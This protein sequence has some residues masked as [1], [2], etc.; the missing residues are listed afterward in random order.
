MHNIKIKGNKNMYNVAIIGAGVIGSSIFAKLTRKGI[1]AVLL[2]KG[3]DVSLGCS[4]ANSGI[5]HAGF[6]AKPNTLKARFNVEGNKM[7]EKVCEELSIPFKKTG[8]FVVGDSEEQI[9]ELIKKGKLNG[10]SNLEKMDRTQMLKYIPNLAEGITFGL[11]AKDSGIVSPYLLTIAMAEEGVINGGEV[12]FNFEVVECTKD[13]EKMVLKSS[14]G[15]TIECQKVINCAGEGYNAVAKILGTEEFSITF[16]RGEYFLL[17]STTY[18]L[19]DYTIF[20]L[21][22]KAGKGILIS[23][24]I[25]GNIIVGPT[26]YESGPSTETTMDGLNMIRNN[27]SKVISNVPLNK[28]IREFSGVRVISGD[29]FVVQKSQKDERVIMLAGICSPGLTSAPSI[30]KYVVEELLGYTNED[31]VKVKR[32][33][34]TVTRD[35]DR[36][37]LNNLIKQDSNYGK[38]VCKCESVTE[39]EILEAINSP[40]RP[41]SVDAIKRRVRAGMGRCQGGFCFMRVIELISQEN[42]LELEDICKENEG[43]NFIMGNIKEV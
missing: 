25:D 4:R 31:V 11:Y 41:K 15:E 21:P 32:K 27:V 28:A 24:T 6:D 18:G 38:I 2:E 8:A 7:M 42:G 17:D 35:M 12:R 1:K 40:L 10:V 19:V 14:K 23:P 9:D 20:P 3:D 26:S 22:T 36:E 33:P 43:S 34:Y 13:N 29:D 37:S 30:A 16:R 39:G 5:V